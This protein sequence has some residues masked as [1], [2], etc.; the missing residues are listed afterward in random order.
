MHFQAQK[1]IYLT[2][3]WLA[4]SQNLNCHNPFSTP[5][6]PF[7]VQERYFAYGTQR[8]WC[9]PFHWSG[10][11][12]NK[13]RVLS[14]KSMIDHKSI[15]KLTEKFWWSRIVHLGLTEKAIMPYPG[16]WSYHIK[17]NRN[18]L[19]IRKPLIS[20]PKNLPRHSLVHFQIFPVL[21]LP[22]KKMC[23][24]ILG[25]FVH[26]VEI[27]LECIIYDIQSSFF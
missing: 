20:Q 14:I 17:K 7:V 8:M 3:F 6:C 10:I 15:Q 1:M 16:S 9:C 12:L 27:I 24:V 13:Y 19:W 18:E 23:F 4:G 11:D 21:I 5:S 26:I 22:A 2:T 25:W